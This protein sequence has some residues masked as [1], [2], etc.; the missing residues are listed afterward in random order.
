M[1]YAGSTFQDAFSK[2]V[3][4]IICSTD[5]MNRARRTMKYMRGVLNGCWIVTMA[6]VEACKAGGCYESEEA[7]EV[8]TNFSSMYLWESMSWTD[9]GCLY[10]FEDCLLELRILS[11]L[12]LKVV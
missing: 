12:V 8:G 11:A 6:W 10:M 9:R 1:Q 4:H 3:T 7:F 2:N 5:D